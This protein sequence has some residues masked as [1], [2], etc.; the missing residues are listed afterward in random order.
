MTL[1]IYLSLLHFNMGV[2]GDLYTFQSS[3]KWP[4]EE[5]Q[6]LSLG[7]GFIYQPVTCCF[8][9]RHNHNTGCYQS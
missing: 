5:L 2:Y 9:L 7:I 4:L 6:F 1:L 8:V 3:L